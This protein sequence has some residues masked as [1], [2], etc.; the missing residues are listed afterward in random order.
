MRGEERGEQE[1]ERKR[2]REHGRARECTREHGRKRESMRE[3]E[4]ERSCKVAKSEGIQE[5]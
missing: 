1:N 3:H 5:Q 2:V 4:Q